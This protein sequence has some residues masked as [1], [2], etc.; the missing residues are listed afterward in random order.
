MLKW[1]FVSVCGFFYELKFIQLTGAFFSSGEQKQDQCSDH[2][3]Q[4]TGSGYQRCELVI[5]FSDRFKYL[6]SDVKRQEAKGRQGQSGIKSHQSLRGVLENKAQANRHNQD[7]CRKV[8][9]EVDRDVFRI[10]YLAVFHGNE[11]SNDRNDGNSEAD[12]NFKQGRKVK[13]VP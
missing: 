5:F 12:H 4:E 2:A 1:I 3:K 13:A 6:V 10:I 11:R 9:Q 8:E 7:F